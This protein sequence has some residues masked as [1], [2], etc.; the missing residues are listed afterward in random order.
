MKNKRAG[1]ILT[2]V[3]ILVLVTTLIDLFPGARL[4]PGLPLEILGFYLL[5]KIGGPGFLLLQAM[6]LAFTGEIVVKYRR[7]R[8]V[9]TETVLTTSLLAAFWI[10]LVNI[11]M[12]YFSPSYLELGVPPEVLLIRD[13]VLWTCIVGGILTVIAAFIPPG[14]STPRHQ[15]RVPTP[16]E[17]TTQYASTPR[18]SHC[19][20]HTLG[21]ERFCRKCGRDL[22]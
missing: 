3:L 1:Y 4:L 18:C 9:G 19:G 14:S 20:E 15:F 22:N 6:V 17:R 11:G 8:Q 2:F 21:D 7:G 12:M 16:S 5:F 13:T 10:F